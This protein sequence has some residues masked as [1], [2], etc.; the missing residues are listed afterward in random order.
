MSINVRFSNENDKI[1][2]VI[3]K[4]F[5]AKSLETA[6]TMEQVVEKGIELGLCE[7]Y[8]RGKKDGHPWWPRT[9][10][11]CGVGSVNA[12]MANYEKYLHRQMVRKSN[13]KGKVMVYWV[14]KTKAADII[15]RKN[16]VTG[17]QVVAVKVAPVIT[18]TRKSYTEE[19]M[20]RKMMENPGKYVMYNGKLYSREFAI[21]HPEKFN[22]M[23]IGLL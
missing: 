13:G 16:K 15:S 7:T 5:G 10:V 23:V 20:E 9:S 11:M 4:I 21:K 6:V 22:S 14:D 17:S 1:M 3:E 2:Y 19:E 12:V 18:E 8:P